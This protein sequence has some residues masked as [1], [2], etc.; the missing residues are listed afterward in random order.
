MRKDGADMLPVVLLERVRYGPLPR[1]RMIGDPAAV[2]QFRR[3]A[4]ELPVV[5]DGRLPGA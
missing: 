4:V 3:V 1:C 2:R 5:K